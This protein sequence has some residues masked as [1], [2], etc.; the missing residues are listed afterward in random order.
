MALGVGEHVLHD[1]LGVVTR[2]G[3]QASESDQAVA[4]STVRILNREPARLV[5]HL[6]THTVVSR[7]RH[8]APSITLTVLDRRI[9]QRRSGEPEA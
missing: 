1:V 7:P 2:V 3:E 6:H 8:V 4:F 5:V 9:G